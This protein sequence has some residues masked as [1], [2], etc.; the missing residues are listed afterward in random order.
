VADF[1]DVVDFVLVAEDVAE[2]VDVADFVLE[3]VPVADPVDVAERVED[4]V[5]VSERVE[6]V[7]AEDERVGTL[8]IVVAG[9][10][11]AAKPKHS[12]KRTIKREMEIYWPSIFFPSL[13][14]PR[15]PIGRK[16][17]GSKSSV[18]SRPA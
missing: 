16:W 6:L 18:C 5:A 14:F 13:R 11:A 7:V 17:W 1:V 4:G 3:A 2:R 9:T 12:S 10:A 15:H 8:V